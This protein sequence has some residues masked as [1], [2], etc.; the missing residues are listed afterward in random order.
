MHHENLAERSLKGRRF[1]KGV[2]R[3]ATALLWKPYVELLVGQRTFVHVHVAGLGEIPVRSTTLSVSTAD[4]VA[5]A[6][7]AVEDAMPVLIGAR[8]VDLR[9]VDHP[10]GDT[11]RHFAARKSNDDDLNV[12]TGLA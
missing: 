7:I 11:S 10:F 5:A 9:I 2:D 8:Y 4:L 12:V 3:F 6:G 1:G